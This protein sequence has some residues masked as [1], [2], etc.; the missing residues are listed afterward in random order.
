MKVKNKKNVI[1]KGVLSVR[2]EPFTVT[3]EPTGEI[4]KA[5][6]SER[7]MGFGQELGDKVSG[8]K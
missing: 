6:R 4:I 5:E 1:Q 2:R 3:W 8:N 7:C